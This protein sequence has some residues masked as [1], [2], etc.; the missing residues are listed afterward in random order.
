MSTRFRRRVNCAK[1]PLVAHGRRAR[2]AQFGAGA[3]VRYPMQ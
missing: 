1:S 3:W 2:R